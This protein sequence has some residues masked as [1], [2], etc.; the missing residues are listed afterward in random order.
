MQFIINLNPIYWYIDAFRQVVLRGEMFSTNHVV[1]C[2][3]CAVIA[4][5]VGCITFKKGQDKFILYI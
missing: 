2:A 3:L 4:M 1:I 5:I